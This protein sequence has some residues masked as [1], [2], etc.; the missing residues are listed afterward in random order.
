MVGFFRGMSRYVFK[1]AAIDVIYFFLGWMVQD[2]EKHTQSV[3]PQ[4]KLTFLHLKMEKAN[5]FGKR[6]IFQVPRFAFRQQIQVESRDLC[7]LSRS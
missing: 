5:P 3:H 2:M 6:S 4:T 1:I 7:C